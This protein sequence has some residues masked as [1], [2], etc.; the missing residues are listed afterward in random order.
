MPE[1]ELDGA[2]LQEL[3]EIRDQ[4][5]RIEFFEDQKRARDLKTFAYAAWQVLEPGTPLIW[6]WHLDLIAEYLQLVRTGKVT[7]LII[8]VPPRTSK[9]RLVSVIFPTWYWL[10]EPTRQFMLV[11]FSKSLTS[12]HARERNSLMDSHEYRKLVLNPFGYRQHTETDTE[13]DCGGRIISTSVG[14]SVT[15]RGANCI[16]MDDLVSQ[17]QSESEADRTTAIRFIDNTLRSRLSDP[18][19]GAMIVVEQRLHERDVTG[20]LLQAEPKTWT[21]V[22]L[23]MIAEEDEEIRFPISGK[24]VRRA[25]GDLLWP[26][27]FPQS[28]C[29]AMKLNPRVWTAQYQ[30]RPTPA[31]GIIFNPANWKYYVRNADRATAECP[32]A[33]KFETVGMSLDCTFKE[34]KDS[35]NVALHVYGTAGPR[36]YLIERDTCPRGYS[37]TKSAVRAMKA[38]YPRASVLLV[39]DKAN[40]SAIIEE[41]SR[42]SLGMS[43]IA[44]NPQGGKTARAWAAQPDQE[45][46]NCY[47]ADDDD[48]TPL[49]VDDMAKFR[50]EGSIPH[51]DD[52]DAFTQW[53]NWRR[54]HSSGFWEWAEERA[55][56]IRE[57]QTAPRPPAPTDPDS[58]LT[59]VE[60]AKKNTETGM[61]TAVA[62]GGSVSRVFGAQ[63]GKVA[64][65]RMLKPAT[66]NHTPACP[67]C[68][69]P[70]LSRREDARGNKLEACACGW[71]T[72]DAA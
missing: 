26:A 62:G 20:H 37:A 21:H 23:P 29:D 49:F 69:N 16:V 57:A 44:V 14:G 53:I 33:P 70:N 40:G 31:E 22:K 11:S 39:E 27:R 10:T 63:L 61:M 71:K 6:N 45:A 30:Q 42:T 9:S 3:Q 5:S 54:S 15:G 34:S 1:L 18:V 46:G 36:N 66:N 32:A 4:L 48:S 43:V 52:V 38:K 58:G 8:N 55:K 7:R 19:T 51:D 28:W 56:E 60:I 64:T 59:A 47:L 72:G 12:Q 24:I 65:S 68:G 67:K 17:Q 2:T 13:S 25:K 41:M 50:G 35:D